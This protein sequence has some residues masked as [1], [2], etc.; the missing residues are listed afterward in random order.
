MIEKKALSLQEQNRLEHCFGCGTNNAKG[1]HIQSYWQGDESV[2]TFQAQ[3]HYHGGKPNIAY[4]G[5]I[6]S[7]I[8]CH[9]VNTAI[10]NAYKEENREPGTEPILVYL[11]AQLNVTYLQPTPLDKPINLKAKI[12]STEGKKTWVECLVTSNNEICAQGKV[13]A[14]RAN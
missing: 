14:I 6:A 8:D 12:I 11:T 1:L 7:L 9:S 5:L 13:L 3:P 4:G 10:S 2:C